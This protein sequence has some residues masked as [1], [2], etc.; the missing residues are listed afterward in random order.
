[1][2]KRNTRTDE[3][4]P[5]RIVPANYKI[6][7][8]Y[9]LATSRNRGYNAINL[10]LVE[11]A[12]AEAAATGVAIFGARGKCGVC[13]AVYLYGDLWK[14]MSGELVHM[15]HECADKYALWADRSEWQLAH[16]RELAKSKILRKRERSAERAATKRAALIEANPDLP[17]LLALDHYITRDIAARYEN[18]GE[19]SVAQINLLRKLVADDATK[20]AKIRERLAELHV[21][22]PE[23]RQTFVGTVVS[24]KERDGFRGGVEYKATIKITVETEQGAATW[25]AW[26]T[27]PSSITQDVVYSYGAPDAIAQLRNT[28][29]GSN[30]EVTATLK[31]GNEPHFAFAKRPMMRVL[32]AEQFPVPNPTKKDLAWVV[33]SVFHIEIDHLLAGIMGLICGCA[34]LRVGTEVAPAP[35]IAA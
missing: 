21:P 32:G 35:A 20:R 24:V 17:Q 2:T 1:M 16:E 19:L 25:M 14:H 22:A 29:V 5:S 18:T 3:H 12:E 10:P 13:G 11:A 15:G 23:G 30:V 6:V 27:V 8:T 4:A 34:A 31:R 28:L 26:A 7:A 9:S 33:G